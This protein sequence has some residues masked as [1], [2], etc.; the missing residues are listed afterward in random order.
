MNRLLTTLTLGVLLGVSAYGA[1]PL[2]AQLHE[3][4]MI[5]KLPLPI[6]KK[7]QPRY[8]Y[9]EQYRY[10]GAGAPGM[11]HKGSEGMKSY[12]SAQGNGAAYGAYHGA[13]TT[14]VKRGSG[15]R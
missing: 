7:E 11:P 15:K 8:Q 4:L 6:L 1:D 5:K 3:R 13:S 14:H 12:R 9:K 2:S 10:K